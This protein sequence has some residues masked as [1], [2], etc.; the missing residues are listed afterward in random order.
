[1][2]NELRHY[3]VMGMKWGKS[4]GIG[5]KAW[6]KERASGSVKF[7]KNGI[8]HPLASAVGTVKT[9]PDHKLAFLTG[10]TIMTN[11]QLKEINNNTDQLIATSKAKKMAKA[12]AHAAKVLSTNG[13]KKV[14]D[15]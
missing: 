13:S 8:T 7:V 4:K 11:K 15:L 2:D 10:G 1:M 12:Q 6:G 5:V 14:K 9:I 3:G